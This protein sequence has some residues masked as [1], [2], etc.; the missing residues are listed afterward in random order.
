MNDVLIPDV[1][2]DPSRP[3]LR[4]ICPWC[5]RVYVAGWRTSDPNVGTVLHAMPTCPM[6]D[7]TEHKAKFLRLAREAGAHVTNIRGEKP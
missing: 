4:G 7:G 5:G 1:D 2:I 6:W 3:S